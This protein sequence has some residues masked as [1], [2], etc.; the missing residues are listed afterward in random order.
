MPD[1]DELRAALR[2]EP[3]QGYRVPD[4]DAVVALGKRIRR[5]RRVA[6]AS[7]AVAV[8]AAVVVVLGLT[9]QLRPGVPPAGDGG[10]AISVAR[11]PAATATSG[12]TPVSP[13]SVESTA[14]ESP[15]PKGDVVPTGIHDEAGEIVLYAV[16]L[17]EAALPDVHFGLAVG[18]RGPSGRLTTDRVANVITGTDRA[19]GFRVFD[20]GT[21][22][23]ATRTWVPAFGYYVGPAARI[24]TT[25]RGKTVEASLASWSEDPNVVFF[26]FTRDEVPDATLA[27]PPRAYAADGSALP[28]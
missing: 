19:P 6:A 10:P 9:S 20:G 25:V 24:T 27:T 13:E 17:D 4:L 5:R 23:T 15:A 28:K 8:A 12:E 3:E 1:I 21:D 11:P 18:H 7:G 14:G 16:G 2:Q 22:E 26:W